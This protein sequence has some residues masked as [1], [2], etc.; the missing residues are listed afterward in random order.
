MFDGQLAWPWER[1]NSI[2]VSTSGLRLVKAPPDVRQSTAYQYKVLLPVEE[3]GKKALELLG[4][5]EDMSG[6]VV[7]TWDITIIQAGS[8]ALP[9]VKVS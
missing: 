4:E 5:L 2:E 9:V 7:G 6:K 8:K 1:A 3:H